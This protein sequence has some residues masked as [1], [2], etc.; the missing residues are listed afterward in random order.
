[1][2]ELQMDFLFVAIVLVLFA[3]TVAAIAALERL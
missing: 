1:L 3:V 2:E